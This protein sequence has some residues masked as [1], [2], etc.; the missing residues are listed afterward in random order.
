MKKA[1]LFF[2]AVIAVSSLLRAQQNGAPA[3]RSVIV[4]NGFLKAQDYLR[5]S[6]ENQRAYAMGLLDGWYMAP[7]FGGP[8]NYKHLMEVEECVEGMRSSQVAAI[9]EKHIREH[10]EGWDWDAKDLGYDAMIDACRR[11]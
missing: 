7:M 11:R 2:L 1:A 6:P 5:L 9:V 3:A 10:P 8:E 4:H